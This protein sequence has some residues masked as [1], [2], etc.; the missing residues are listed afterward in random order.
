MPPGPHDA[1]PLS[2][3]LAHLRDRMALASVMG[4][5]SERATT[6]G[7]AP[8]QLAD[9]RKRGWTWFSGLESD[10]RQLAAAAHDRMHG[11][12]ST[13]ATLTAPLS[14]RLEKAANQVGS[15]DP[16]VRANVKRELDAIDEALIGCERQLEQAMSAWSSAVDLALARMRGGDEAL[17]A[18]ASAGF[19][20]P[21]GERPLLVFGASWLDAPDPPP[22]LLLFTDVRVR[23]ERRD[24]RIPRRNRMGLAVERDIDRTILLDETHEALLSARD[25]STGFV[26]KEPR[27][28]LGL[29]AG[30]TTT[31]RLERPEV[32]ELLALCESWRR[33]DLSRFR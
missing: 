18:F 30:R 31:L 21:P 22:G 16:G 20:L 25:A 12:E 17:S 10:L 7:G 19:R 9:L 13:R 15:A 24:D 26:V 3:Q 23:Y 29:S 8:A 6:V 2:A 32:A 1:D 4:P 28:A 5:M 33:G 14:P 27:I 11:A